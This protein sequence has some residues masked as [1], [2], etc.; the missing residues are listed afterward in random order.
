MSS[1]KKPTVLLI[2]ANHSLR[3]LIALGLQSRGMRVREADSVASIAALDEGSEQSDLLVLDIDSDIHRD[4]SSLK[5]IQSHPGLSQLPTVILTW[6]EQAS[7]KLCALLPLSTITQAQVM[8]QP[9]PFDARALFAAIE[10]MLSVRATEKA[11][12]EAKAEE[13]LLAAYAVYT[14]PSIW[15]IIT[16]LGLLLAVIGI[17][18]QVAISVIG[19]LIVVVALLLW[20]LR[21]GP[22]HNRVALSSVV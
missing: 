5:A 10:Q 19:C 21:A 3:R 13:A 16:A 7:E 20:A 6:E 14:A 4:W 17:L 11:A 1:E 9:K 15:P 12:L 2:E 18:F 8:C 22:V